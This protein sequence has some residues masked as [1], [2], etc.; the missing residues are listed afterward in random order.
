VSIYN[1]LIIY[2]VIFPRIFVGV[3][4]LLIHEL[5][6][7]PSQEYTR[8]YAVLIKYTLPPIPA[9]TIT[10]P[11]PSRSPSTPRK[12]TPKRSHA[13]PLNLED[14]SSDTG[15]PLSSTRASLLHILGVVGRDDV[16]ARLGVVHDGLGMRE[17]AVE[18]PV[19]D[20]GGDEGVDVADA[21]TA[22]VE[23]LARL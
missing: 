12:I 7:I 14:L 13:L 5:L 3:I 1:L 17:E 16:L 4:Y 6:Y 20:A 21:E 15:S 11:R 2:K 19:E 8:L 22:Q 9:L 18:A 23:M 10:S